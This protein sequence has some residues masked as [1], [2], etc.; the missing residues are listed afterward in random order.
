[1]LFR[2]VDTVFADY[3]P[4]IVFHAAAHKHVPLMED[5]PNEAIKNNVFG[6]Y[7]VAMAAGRTGTER[8]VLISTDKAVN[9]TNIMG[10]SK[11]ICE[12]IIQGMQH[13]FT[14]TNYVAVRFGNV[15]GS[16]GSVIPL[17]KKQIAEGGPVTV[18]DKNIIRYFMTIPEAVS[19]V[20][21]LQPE[22]LIA[23]IEPILI[24]CARELAERPD[25]ADGRK[26][27]TTPCRILADMGNKLELKDT[28]FVPWNRFLASIGE[29][30]EPAPDA[31]PIPPG[32]FKDLPFP[33]V[34]KSGR[35]AIESYVTRNE[36]KDARLIE[37]LYCVQGC[38]RG[39]G[40][41]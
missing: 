3:K 28:H 27:I 7:N 39:D 9:P 30:M 41:R 14:K 35:P 4:A 12:M 24:H 31:S 2:S 20:R 1:M 21:S 40:V 19:L 38:H 10:A 8:M 34:S 5:S 32:F 33:V 6:T 29:P 16:N 22:I 11:R 23:D 17:F 36:W 26:I 15:L 25:L 18:T 13:R 37:L